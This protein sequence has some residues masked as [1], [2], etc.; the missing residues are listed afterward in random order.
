MASGLSLTLRGI[1][2]KPPSWKCICGGSWA[3]HHRKDGKGLLKKYQD[4]DKHRP[5]TGSGLNRA[6]RRAMKHG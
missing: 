6:Q 5:I 4:T 3:D 1:V 2:Q